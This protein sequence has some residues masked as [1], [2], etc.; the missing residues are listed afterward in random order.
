MTVSV[1]STAG[2]NQFENAINSILKYQDLPKADFAHL[3]GVSPN[4]VSDIL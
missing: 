4:N 3:L 2:Q 1:G